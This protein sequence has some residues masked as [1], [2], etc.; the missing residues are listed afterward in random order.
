MSDST[1]WSLNQ[2]VEW[3]RCQFSQTGGGLPFSDVL[4]AQVVIESLRSMG[5]QFYESLYNPVTVL[6]LFL[7]QVVHANPTLAA[8]VENFIAWRMGQGLPPCSTDTGGS[9]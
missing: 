7:S 9:P 6:W 8:T 1:K 3:F 5:L 2:H 4:P